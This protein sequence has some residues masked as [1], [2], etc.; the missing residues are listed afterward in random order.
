MDNQYQVACYHWSNWHPYPGNDRKRGTG[1]TEWEY[2][3]SAIP[4]FVGHKQPKKPLW[5][6]LDDTKTENAELQIN[7]AAD[8]GISAFIFDWGYSED[9]GFGG[10]GNNLALE[11][12]FLKAPS[13]DRLQFGL[14]W[15]G[16]MGAEAFR[17][18]SDYMI[19]TYFSQPN[20]W[21]VDG[22][23]YL[24]VYE[25]HKFIEALGGVD[26]A[27]ES[28]RYLRDQTRKAGYGEV[29]FA[30]VEWGVQDQ[31]GSILGDLNECIRKMTIDSVTSYAWC[32][33]TLPNDG[34]T[35][36]YDPW[37]KDAMA[38][39]KVF[40]EKF[41]V[42]YFPHV[43]VG[44]DPSPRCPATMQYKIGGPLMYHT[45]DGTYEILHEPYLST[46]VS[47]NAPDQFKKALV[48]ARKHL[49]SKPFPI[50][51]VVT[52]YAW[53]EWTEGGYLEPEEQYGYGYLEA[54]REVFGRS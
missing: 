35:G 52:L 36:S 46:I 41:S 3:K 45:L 25:M 54:I 14:M 11:E 48:Q 53:N 2:L 22:G 33:N 17:H 31:H 51:K 34:L 15:C 28:I 5:G 7:T 47:P 30:A 26:K 39:W 38:F 21:R 27:A 50:P 18:A 16:S 6:Y 1:W 37:A 19:K 29:H 24:S 9:D 44:W 20:Y 4:R 49:D 13:R 8:Y 40:D 12:G 23:L 42:P 43:S 10:H 32:H